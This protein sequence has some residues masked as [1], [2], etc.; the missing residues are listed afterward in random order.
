[1]SSSWIRFHV[2]DCAIIRRRVLGVEIAPRH[3]LGAREFAFEGKDESEILAHRFVGIVLGRGFLQRRFGLRQFFRKR[4]GNSEIGQNMRLRRHDFERRRI[5]GL[6]LLVV[7]E[8]IGD[9]ALRG[10]HGPIRPLGGM[11]MSQ[12]VG[13]LAR[14]PGI[15]QG[16]AIGG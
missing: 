15:G 9:R 4:V 8:L 11:G 7:A 10:K 1:M 13:R 12:H 5:V 16:L 6:R 2:F 14:P 3:L